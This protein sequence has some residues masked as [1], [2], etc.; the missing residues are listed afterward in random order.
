MARALCPLPYRSDHPVLN[1]WL[2]SGHRVLARDRGND[3]IPSFPSL[4]NHL[5]PNVQAGPTIR[6][7]NV[8]LLVHLDRRPVLLFPVNE[9]QPVVFVEDTE[10]GAL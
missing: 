7:R 8:V 9:A 3:L 1:P 10:V 4:S 5:D 6:I 2:V